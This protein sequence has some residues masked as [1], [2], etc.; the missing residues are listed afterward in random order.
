MK[1]GVK[2]GTVRLESYSSEWSKVYEIE[3]DSLLSIFK[4]YALAIEHIGSTAIPNLT[5][6]PLIDIAIQVQNID[7]LPI[8]EALTALGYI[9]KIGRL[10]GRQRVFSKAE[11]GIVTHHLHVIEKGEPA[12]ERKLRFKAIL[13][14]QPEVVQA[15]VALKEELKVKYQHERRKYTEGKA[16]FINVVLTNY[17]KTIE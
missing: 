1:L 7:E 16:E 3:K 9:E 14:E 17:Q 11:D 4:S 2:K 10:S 8:I 6:K 13:L 15:Y 12:W 5:A